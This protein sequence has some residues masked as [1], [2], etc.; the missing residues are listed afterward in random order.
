MR[1]VTYINAGAGSGKTYTLTRILAEKLSADEGALNPSQVILTTFTE[2]AAT[3]FRE[4]ARQQILEKE[5]VDVAAQMDS[6][7]IGTVHSV[8]LTF[9]KKFW[10]LLEY[11]AEIQTISERDADFY[12]SQSLSRVVN[13]KANRVHMQN[14][15]RFRDNFNIVDSYGHPDYLFWKEYLSAIVEKMEYYCV[16]DVE[17]SIKMSFETARS[18]YSEPAVTADDIDA[19]KSYLQQYL[20]YISSV[21]SAAA[22]NQRITINEL[23][24]L[25]CTG[26]LTPLMR[27]KCISELT[28]LMRT[29]EMMDAPVGGATKIEA[30][31]PGFNDFCEK[32]NRL[33]LSSSNMDV[34]GPFIESVFRMAAMWRSDYA[35]YKK[36]NHIISYNDMEQIFLSLLDNEEVMDYVSNNYRLVMVD[37]FQDSNP[38]QLKIF[39][40]LSEIIARSGGHS[41][42]VGDPKQ[43]IYGFRGADTELVNSVS[44]MFNFYDDDKIHSEEGERS[45][46]TGRLVESWRSREALVR[47]VNKVFKDSFIAD[48]INRLCIELQ[49]HFTEDKLSAPA[50]VSLKSAKGVSANDALACKIKDVLASGMLVHRGRRDT[51]PTEIAPFDIAVLCRDN[52]SCR[53]IVKALRKYGVPV[54]EVE[55][56]IMQRI[57]VQLVVNILRFVQ[58]PG[59]KSII[60]NL[61]RLLWGKS[62]GEILCDRIAYVCNPDNEKDCWMQENDEVKRLLE[63]R[64]EIRHLPIPEMV[65][66]VV[67]KSNAPTLVA[68]WGDEQ[69]RRQNLSTLI[70]LAEDYDHMCQQMGLGA[71]ISGLIYYLDSIEPDKEKDNR[72]NTV[73][74]FTYHSSKGLE[75][76]LVIMADLNK[77]TL[78]DADFTKKTFMRV[79]EVALEGEAADG[80]PLSK[81]YYIHC[82]PKTVCGSVNPVAPLQDKIKCHKLYEQLKARLKSE[83][84]RLLYVGM[85]R[86]KDYL[87]TIDTNGKFKWLENVD[88]QATETDV[89]GNG[90]PI[91]VEHIAP[92]DEMVDADIASYSI[93]SKPTLRTTRGRKYLSPSKVE[94]FEG[95]SSHRLWKK[96]GKGLESAEWKEKDYTR[97]GLCVHDIFAVYRP[98]AREENR[99]KA[100]RIIDGYGFS[101]TMDGRVDDIV[102]SADWL[103]AQLQ[104]NFPQCNGDS[105]YNEYPFET[106]LATGEHLRGEMDLLWFYS[107]EKG[108]HCVIVDYKSFPGVNLNTHTAKYYAQMSAYAYALRS[109]GIDVT[110][111]FVYYPLQGCMNEVL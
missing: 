59:N 103:Y 15:R 5:I 86:A 37:E 84:R 82:F 79:R 16:E 95:Y 21:D 90:N 67:Y 9:I 80:N 35:A 41:Y 85:T 96:S 69:I 25:K 74:V 22:K 30:K 70:R 19:V 104:E 13:D 11:G 98:G 46:G 29:K 63:M 14:F 6:A 89:W 78:N 81:E 94:S 38:I 109:A 105:F 102:Q 52:S 20:D 49:P 87:Y 56:S 36:N 48:G 8:A 111:T 65:R 57:E 18:I 23:L 88:I 107:D 50:I 45:L 40:K 71:S 43:A 34:I 3:E 61:M 92:I 24:C 73:K 100:L 99:T 83:E 31:C 2:L 68:R 39:D 51:L 55:D 47:L 77:D 17:E 108:S 93:V 7:V 58:D 75:W 4:K 106:R 110:H 10:Y 33:I 1:N 76:P 91:D 28:A 27:I 66:A 42:W 26:K 54:A 72:S 64:E 101:S 32:V 12:M 53:D 44:K 97:V 62:T 60:A